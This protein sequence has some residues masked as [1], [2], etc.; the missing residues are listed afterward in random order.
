MDARVEPKPLT[1]DRPPPS[2]FAAD[3]MSGTAALIYLIVFALVMAG[4]ITMNVD[5]SFLSWDSQAWPVQFQT[6]LRFGSPFSSEISNPLSGM[7]DIFPMG[8]RGGQ[9]LQLAERFFGLPVDRRAMLACNAALLTGAL[10]LFARAAGLPRGVAVLGAIL[11]PVTTMSVFRHQPLSDG[12][13]VLSSY[14]IYFSAFSTLALALFWTIDGKSVAR[15]VALAAGMTLAMLHLFLVM[16]IA[17]SQVLP[18]ILALGL[19]GLVAS[20]TRRELMAKVASVTGGT[21]LLCALGVA[22]YAYAIGSY[23]SYNFFFEEL[24]DFALRSAPSWQSF[25]DDFTHV[26]ML[27]RPESSAV[28]AIVA[29]IGALV[30]AVTDS[31]RRVRVLAWSMLAWIAMT[32]VA[33]FFAHY[34]YY[35]TGADYKGLSGYHFGHQLNI[36]YP[37]FLAYLCVFIGDRLIGHSAEPMLVASALRRSLRHVL[38]IGLLLL[39]LVGGR[40]AAWNVARSPVP[41]HNPITELLAREIG[42]EP[43]QP[44]RGVA[45]NMVRVD[46]GKPTHDVRDFLVTLLNGQRFLGNDMGANGLWYLDIPT[47]F[48]FNETTSPQYFLMVSELLSR[49]ADRHIRA[50]TLV[51]RTNKPILELWGV[52]FLVTDHE[53]PFGLQRTELAAARPRSREFDKFGGSYRLYELPEPN[54]GN[55]S[56]TEVVG[57]ATANQVVGIMK[58]QDFD[59]R[60]TVLVDRPTSGNFVGATGGTITVET[61]G[62]SIRAS[63]AGES[64]LVLPVQYS[65]CWH[66]EGAGEAALFRANL[67][68]L[69]IRFSG[70]LAAR[71][72][73]VFGPFGHSACR[74]R[75]VDDMHRLEVAAARSRS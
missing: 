18:A 69:G 32:P 25:G 16:A 26:L 62:F 15:T 8:Y 13:F 37:I 19:G 29:I 48:S 23:T 14:L 10:Y 42:I 12:V 64:L 22:S 72:R 40:V 61:G 34:F 60:R 38:V 58:S 20:E 3:G 73:L 28:V 44:F 11:G 4:L 21:L 55:Y 7:F 39:T 66:I 9:L 56:P 51:T 43:G 50:Y 63:S 70:E 71:L 30:A 75:D 1:L 57:Y 47:L 35:F 33:T 74:F 17:V 24:N 53:L 27:D 6:F 68:Q 59:G 31:S 45:N 46:T 2:A 5:Q 49:P 41:A 65:N 52:R 36:F 67:L 54:L